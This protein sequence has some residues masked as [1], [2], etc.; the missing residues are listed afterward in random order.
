MLVSTP[1]IAWGYM[2]SGWMSVC[3]TTQT[4]VQSR[5]EMEEKENTDTDQDRGVCSPPTT[6]RAIVE[7]TSERTYNHYSTGSTIVVANHSKDTMRGAG[8]S[9]KSVRTMQPCRPPPNFHVKY[10]QYWS[11]ITHREMR[12]VCHPQ[13]AY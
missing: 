13:L 9:R 12:H 2:L 6:G 10:T 4:S 1:L 5:D 8:R 7:N 11:R 3:G